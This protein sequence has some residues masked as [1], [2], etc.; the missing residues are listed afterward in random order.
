MRNKAIL[1]SAISTFLFAGIST[2]QAQTPSN[3][4]P[5]QVMIRG[6]RADAA[7]VLA[8][9]G[10]IQSYSCPAPEQYTTPDGASQGWACFDGSTNVWLLSALPPQGTQAPP[11]APVIQ[12]PAQPVQQ[13]Y[14]PVILQP[15]YQ[16]PVY[17]QPV[18]SVVYY[19]EPAYPIVYREPSRV[20]Y[21]APSYPRVVE[22]VYT[23]TIS[24]GIGIGHNSRDDHHD[25]RGRRR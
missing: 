7:Y 13:V 21:T 4:I 20:I 6:Q 18:T 10:G 15:V 17:Q 11:A 12:A 23:P 9:A 1:L 25:D 16:Q 24:V 22:R 3:R 8:P 5:Q 2:L 19:Y 14:Q